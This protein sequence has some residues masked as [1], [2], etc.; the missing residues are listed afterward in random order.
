MNENTK[1]VVRPKAP[2]KLVPRVAVPSAA[3]D[4]APAATVVATVEAVAAAPAVA[5]RKPPRKPSAVDEAVARHQKVLA[6]ALTEAQAIRYETP[7]VVGGEP[8][9]GKGEAKAEKAGKAEKRR[10]IRLVR[11]SFAMPEAEYARIGALKKRLAGLRRDTRKNEL[12]RAGILLLDALNDAE[13]TAVM[14]RIERIKTGR[15]KG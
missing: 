10:K 1:K 14:Q 4:D 2:K 11:D 7:V 8:V 3:T 5:V 9:A 13:L 12:L 15:P 6:D